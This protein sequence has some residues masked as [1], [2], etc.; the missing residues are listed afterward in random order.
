[1]NNEIC[2]EDKGD[3]KH[4]NGGM[5]LVD[6]TNPKVHKY[7]VE[8]F[9]DLQPDGDSHEIHSVFIW[10]AGAKAYAVLVDNEEAADVDIIDITDPRNPAKIAEYDLAGMFPGIL[11]PGQGLDASSTTTSWS[12]KSRPACSTC[13][14]RTGTAATSCS[15]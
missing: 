1:M 11:Q 15:T 9:G 4:P 2:N 8:H 12:R 7:L 5:T 3:E 13:S 6:V 10:D 14:F